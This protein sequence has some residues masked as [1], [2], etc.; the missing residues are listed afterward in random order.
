MTF[1]HSWIERHRVQLRN[2]ARYGINNKTSIRLVPQILW[3]WAIQC[4]AAYYCIS[5]DNENTWW[6]LCIRLLFLSAVLTVTTAFATIIYCRE[7]VNGIAGC[8]R[9]YSAHFFLV[10]LSFLELTITVSIHESV[11]IALV[12]SLIAAL[13]KISIHFFWIVKK[14]ETDAFSKRKQT[15]SHFFNLPYSFSFLLGFSLYWIC[16]AFFAEKFISVYVVIMM[17][18]L[19]A[20]IICTSMEYWLKSVFVDQ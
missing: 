15:Q 3:L 18:Y 13:V 10:F 4:A 12:Y 11:L 17:G 6:G 19:T 7:K 2:Y 16:K 20:C 14:V 9:Y 5:S 8:F 1:C